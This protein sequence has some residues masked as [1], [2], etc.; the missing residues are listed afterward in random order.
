MLNGSCGDPA[1]SDKKATPE[2]WSLRMLVSPPYHLTTA[3]VVCGEPSA[4]AGRRHHR[5]VRRGRGAL[6]FQ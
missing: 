1:I 6:V 2:A 4:A 5:L 3:F